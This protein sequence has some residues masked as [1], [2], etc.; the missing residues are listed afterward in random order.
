MFLT[1]SGEAQEQLVAFEG[2]GC[3]PQ[4]IPEERF[5]LCLG[6]QACLGSKV[7][8]QGTSPKITIKNL[9]KRCDQFTS[10]VSCVFFSGSSS[11][12]LALPSLPSL[13][14]LLS[15]FTTSSSSSTSPSSSSS[16]S[17]SEPRL[18]RAVQQRCDSFVSQNLK[19]RSRLTMK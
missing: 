19:H 17:S 6:Q 11:M 5:S 13:L 8:I 4:I 18:R 7:V 15:T 2:L 9:T 1:L 3:R 16:S 14:L 10:A 12:S